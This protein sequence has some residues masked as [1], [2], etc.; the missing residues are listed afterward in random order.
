MIAESI[1]LGPTK[2]GRIRQLTE[3][4][5]ADELAIHLFFKLA[6]DLFCIANNSGYLKKI[7][8]A[9][10]LMLGWTEFELMSVPIISY[11]HHEDIERT[12]EIMTMMKYQD[13]IRFHNRFK[14]KP[15]TIN[16]VDYQDQT[17]AG[18]DDYVVLE[19]NSTA[20]SN[21]LTYSVARQVPISCLM[22]PESQNRFKWLHR[23]SRA[24]D[25][26]RSD[27]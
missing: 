25:R 19:W 9:W 21:D 10:N 12:N 1:D 7:N 2:L 26:K 11:V 20:W 18:D 4:L 27:K 16:K 23:S 14:R 24:Y 3:E 17:P 13:I 15:G 8:Q 5:N 6:P 22:C